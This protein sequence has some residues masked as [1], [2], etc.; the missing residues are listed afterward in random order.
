MQAQLWKGEVSE[1]KIRPLS[2]AP[3]VAALCPG[4]AC[5]A[6]GTWLASCRLHCTC[7][8]FVHLQWFKCFPPQF[9]DYCAICLRW[10]WPGSPKALEKCNLEAAFFEGHFLK[11]L[12]DRM[13]RILDQVICLEILI[14]LSSVHS[15]WMMSVRHTVVWCSALFPVDLA[16]RISDSFLKTFI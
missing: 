12:F 4:Q 11:V 2:S 14:F 15:Q 3:L 9:R 6:A 1:G 10:E 16:C 5:E 8:L 7:L 13:G